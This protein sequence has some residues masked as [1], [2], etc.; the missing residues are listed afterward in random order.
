MLTVVIDYVDMSDN[1]LAD[2]IA[3]LRG[4]LQGET[5]QLEEDVER[6]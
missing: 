2:R 5:K 6:C 1:F 4:K 3:R